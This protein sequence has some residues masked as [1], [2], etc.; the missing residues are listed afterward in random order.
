M[1]FFKA[2]LT[3]ALSFWMMQSSAQ[4]PL[5]ALRNMFDGSAVSIECE[6]TT[7]IQQTQVAGRSEIVVQGNMYTMKGNGLEVYCDG[8]TVWTIDAAAQEV[9]IE[10][11]SPQERD[12]MANPALLLSDIDEVFK[13]RG[14]RSLDSGRMEYTMDSTVRCGISKAVLVLA[15][16]GMIIS[17]DFNLD[18]GGD[19][20]V[21]VSSMKKTEE[22]QASFFSPDRKF[23]SDW[24]VTDL[25]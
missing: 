22:K 21:N 1:K 3:T 11:C 4:M 23:D 13:M 6:Y 8:N 19:L 17:A 16:D 20:K 9:V 18:E 2:I 24:I 15:Q 10:P 25:R 5:E 14:S 7:E 12:Y